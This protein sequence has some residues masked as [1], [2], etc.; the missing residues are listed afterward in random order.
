M[1][2]SAAAS[3]ISRRSLLGGGAATALSAATYRSVIG[4]NDRIGLGFIGFGLIGKRH[5]LDFK[6]QSDAQIMAIA[7]VHAGRRDEA[8]ALA[9][10]SARG[11]T[12]FRA[13]L[14]DHN[15]DA[16]VVSTPDHWHA[17]MTML[18]CAANKDVYVE[19]PLSLFP[20]EGRW[21]IDVA[22]RHGR[23]VQVGT[24]QRSGPHYQKARELVRGGRIGQIVAVRMWS[25]RNVM[26]GFGSP[27]DCEPPVEL[28]YDRWLGPAPKRPYNPNRA[29]YHFRWFWDYSGGQMTNLGQH[30][31][32]IVHWFL[33]ATGPTA[34]SSAGGRFALKD[35]GETPDT[36]DALFEYPGW[37]ATWSQREC[38]RGAAPATG[39][40]FCGTAGSL[41]ISRKGFIVTP[42]PKVAPAEVIPRF[43]AP[44]PVGGPATTGQRELAASANAV[45]E[46]RSGDEFDQFKR[47]ARNF[48]DCVRSRR[49]PISELE[50]AHGVATA[51]HLANLSLRL[52]RKLRWDAQGE[53]VVADPEAVALLERPYR[54]PWNAERDALIRRG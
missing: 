27:S 31:L 30:S 6:D 19:K 54:A 36:Q 22:R 39:L 40:E 1:S 11:H 50:G 37:T 23:V 21:M 24:Q 43:G 9:G 28:D 41:K 29:I 18:A 32:D 34:V 46:D 52:G 16:V 12:D 35:N 10:G 14:D 5:L 7:D 53:T 33:E 17:L 42:D 3:V 20:R 38:S 47:H 48:L 51:C 2:D 45:V 44:H 26:P 25:Y 4:A 8:V 15:I 49:D 13:L